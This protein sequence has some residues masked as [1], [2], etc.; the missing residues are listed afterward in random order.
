MHVFWFM[1]ESIP[2]G[3]QSL[4][5]RTTQ[6][7]S[8][9]VALFSGVVIGFLT[10]YIVTFM[11]PL[12]YWVGLSLC[13]VLLALS[14]YLFLLYSPNASIGEAEEIVP[15]ALHE[16]LHSNFDKLLCYIKLDWEGYAFHKKAVSAIGWQAPISAVKVTT[17]QISSHQGE[18]ELSYPFLRIFKCKF[19]L[20]IFV[21]TI[22]EI[23]EYRKVMVAIQMNAFARIHPKSDSVLRTLGIRLE[24]AITNPQ[25]VYPE[26]PNEEY[27]KI[28]KEIR[29][30]V[31]NAYVNKPKK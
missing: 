23:P 29:P 28:L 16:F 18:I 26:I 24:H 1:S 31:W 5:E 11:F 2:S 14:I 21:T 22:T 27:H 6:Y 25:I 12:S 10:N 3:F 17:T 20:S 13:F 19:K 8:Y 30:S 4:S 9:I 7:H 15:Q